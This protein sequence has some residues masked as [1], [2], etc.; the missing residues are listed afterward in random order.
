MVADTYCSVVD[1]WSN[2]KFLPGDQPGRDAAKF[3]ARYFPKV[4]LST[5]RAQE[6]AEIVDIELLKRYPAH[7]AV[8][9]VFL[10]PDKQKIEIVS[11]STVNTFLWDGTKWYKPKEIIDYSLPFP[12]YPSDA[13]TFF[14]RG[15]LKIDPFYT[16]K[17]DALTVPNNQPILVT[18]DGL[19]DVMTMDE[20]P[21]PSP[22]LLDFLK[23]EIH[24]QGTQK[25]DISLLLYF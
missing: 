14:G 20:I 6:A 10:F 25:D 18:T 4:F 5:R 22:T 7:V 15:E 17:A 9:G 23:R 12:E 8:V 16:I 21:K 11:V 3:I 24:K 2:E 19:N 13:R 1:G